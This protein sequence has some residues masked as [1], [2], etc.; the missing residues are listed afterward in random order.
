VTTWPRII[1]MVERG[2]YPVH[3]V[4]TAQIKTDDVVDKG[5]KTLLDPAG[6][7]RSPA[8]ADP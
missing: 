4:I 7:L 5:F 6:T 1:G 3:K 2:V 8:S